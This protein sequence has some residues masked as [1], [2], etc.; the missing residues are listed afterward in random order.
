MTRGAPRWIRVSTSFRLG[1]A[2]GLVA[3]ATAS[4][5]LR[6]LPHKE[7]TLATRP[8]VC[9]LK[10]T[11]G[12][13]CLACRGTRAA[14]ALGRG[15]LPSALRYNPLATLLILVAFAGSTFAATTG[16]W[17]APP[18]LTSPW[19]TVAWSALGLALAANWAYVIAAGG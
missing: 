4:A 1:A 9:L 6:T 12:V 13:P 16:R 8:S 18:R 5:V 17:P 15:D 3:A 7:T 14:L 10:L 19:P 11:T 2:L